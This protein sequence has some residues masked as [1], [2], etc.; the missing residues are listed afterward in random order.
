MEGELQTEKFLAKSSLS[1]EPLQS[2]DVTV[3]YPELRYVTHSS[4]KRDRLFYRAFL[5]LVLVFNSVWKF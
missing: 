3:I 2:L 4:L 1:V 5:D